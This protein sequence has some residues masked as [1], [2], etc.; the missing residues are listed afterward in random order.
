MKVSEY[1]L[2][3]AVFDDAFC[4]MLSR[5][6]DTFKDCPD[7]FQKEELVDLALDRCW[8]EFTL[9]LEEDGIILGGADVYQ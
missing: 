2:L 8:N 4:N 1:T 9:A 3:K 5:I 7:F 6:G